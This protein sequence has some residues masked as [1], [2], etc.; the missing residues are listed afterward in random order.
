MLILGNAN[1]TKNIFKCASLFL[2]LWHM[3][4]RPQEKDEENLDRSRLFCSPFNCDALQ[5]GVRWLQQWRT[6]YIINKGGIIAKSKKDLPRNLRPGPFWWWLQEKL[7]I[8]RLGREHLILKMS[9]PFV[10][11]GMIPQIKIALPKVPPRVFV[12]AKNLAKC[13]RTLLSHQ[14][15]YLQG[16]IKK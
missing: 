14:L 8:T 13:S 10:Q 2:F 9:I 11:D 5:C 12:R 1:R 15:T 6:T 16:I 3:K 7:F 4:S